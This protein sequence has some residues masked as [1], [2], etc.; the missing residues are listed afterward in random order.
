[1]TKSKQPRILVLDIETG[2]GKAF[3]W[4][5]FDTYIPLERVIEP[6]RM[7]CFAAKFVGEKEVYFG[8][9][10]TDGR[11]QMLQRLTALINEADAVVTFN[12]DKFDF[13]KI[14]GEVIAAGLP[15]FAPPTSIDL[16]KTVRGLGYTSGKMDYVAQF[17]KLGSKTKHAGFALWRDVLAGCKK[18]QRKMTKYNIQDIKLTERLY[19]KLRPYIA[20]HPTLR[21]NEGKVKCPVCGGTH[22]QHRGYRYTMYFKTAR[23]ECQNKKCGKWFQGKRTKV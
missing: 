3:F 16:Y 17:L 11:I 14:R 4:N 21:D 12:G 2:P 7:L 5:L 23:L 1:M 10:W 6:G 18:A 15:P 13:R 20:N 9:E 19:K 22:H 8:S